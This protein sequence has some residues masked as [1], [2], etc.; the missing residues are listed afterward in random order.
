MNQPSLSSLTSYLILQPF[1]DEQADTHV[2]DNRNEIG[3]AQVREI[4]KEK[5]CGWSKKCRLGDRL[6]LNVCYSG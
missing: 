3:F 6:S 4:D 2:A 1:P 5:L